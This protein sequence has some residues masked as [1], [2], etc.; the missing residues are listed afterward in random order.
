MTQL[1]SKNLSREKENAAELKKPSEQ[2]YNNRELRN[3][4]E[5][6]NTLHWNLVSETNRN[7]KNYMK[8]MKEVTTEVS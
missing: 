3:R 4:K 5:R 2:I 7:D 6:Q 1:S 8:E